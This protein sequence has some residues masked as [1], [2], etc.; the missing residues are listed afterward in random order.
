[1]RHS[2]RGVLLGAIRASSEFSWIHRETALRELCKDVLPQ[3]LLL[4]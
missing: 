3:M 1:M 2:L 4:Q